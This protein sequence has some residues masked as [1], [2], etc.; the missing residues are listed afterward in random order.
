MFE[1]I[2]LAN[3]QS[4]V[5]AGSKNLRWTGRFVRFAACW[6]GAGWKAGVSAVE[7]SIGGWDTHGQ[8]VNGSNSVHHFVVH[9]E[10]FG[11]KSDRWMDSAA[12]LDRP[13]GS[14]RDRLQRHHGRFESS[15][16]LEGWWHVLDSS[17]QKTQGQP[18]V[19]CTSLCFDGTRFRQKVADW[20]KPPLRCGP[21]KGT[22]YL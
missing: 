9:A 5:V 21:V 13:V 22:D 3:R 17:P 14:P 7:V 1:G 11:S 8:N 4:T 18:Q 12:T 20:R 6:P 2:E 16:R 19:G 10:E 15:A